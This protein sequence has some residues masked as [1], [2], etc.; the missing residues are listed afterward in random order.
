MTARSRI[1][2]FGAIAA[3]FAVAV[4][5]VLVFGHRPDAPQRTVIDVWS[6]TDRSAM[7]EILAGFEAAHPGI[8]IR[9]TEYNTSELREAVLAARQKPDV[10][11][12]SAMDLQVELVNRG[13]ASPVADVPET[14]EWSRWREELFGFTQEPVALVYNREAFSKRPLPS[15]R[16]ELAGM[17]RDEPSFFDGRVGTYD[18]ALSGVGYM[19]ATQDAQRGFQ[20]P[21][22]VES[23]GRAKAKTYCCTNDMVEDVA[24]GRLVLAYNVIGSYALERVRRDP[25]LGILLLSDYALVFT[26]SVLVT[27]DSDDK[28]AAG[29]FVRFLLSD[30]GQALIDESS[31][32]FPLVASFREGQSFFET[33]FEGSTSLL[34]IRLRPSLLTWLDERKKAKFLHDWKASIKGPPK[35]DREAAPKKT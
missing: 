15:T 26:R 29:D 4:V 19:F 5:P 6:A 23:F 1:V 8:A 13:L 3:L 34:P 24:S 22:L 21:R 10:V 18:V 17:I 11:V 2:V 9:Y 27:K 16:S 7:A 32:L 35:D 14:P 28:A 31:S 30:A 25:R 33:R 20:A 12:S